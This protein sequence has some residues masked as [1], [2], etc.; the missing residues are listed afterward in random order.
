MHKA[1]LGIIGFGFV[2]RALAHGFGP[3]ADIKIYDKYENVYNSLEETVNDSDFLF[4][5]VPTPVDKNGKQDLSN[6]DDA[7]GSIVKVPVGRKI[8]IL[9]STIVPGTTRKYAERHKAHDFIFC[10]EFL[11]ERTAKLDFI[12]ASRIIIGGQDESAENKVEHLYRSRFTH[13]PI[14]KTTWEVAE[15]LKY[16]CNCFFAVKISFLNEMY[17]ITNKFLNVSFEELRDM[18][19]ADFRIGNSHKDVPGPDGY[20]GY[21]GKCFPK[22]VKSFITWA[23]SE[24]LHLDMCRAADKVNERVRVDKD[25]LRIKGA[26]SKNNY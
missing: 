2:G 26:T 9:K 5:G 8:I 1:R 4:I 15:V 19:L 3:V 12:N 11:T 21:G 17:D 10:P 16:M 14:Y 22:D 7:I 20:R 6:L 25:W 24:K 23:E 18:W 13:T